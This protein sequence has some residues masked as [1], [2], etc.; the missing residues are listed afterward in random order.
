MYDDEGKEVD[1]SKG[2]KTKIFNYN[3][4]P[5]ETLFQKS[6]IKLAY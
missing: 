1:G 3:S 5:N 4:I 2:G 6:N